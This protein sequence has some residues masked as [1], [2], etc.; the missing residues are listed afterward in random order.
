MVIVTPAKV[1]SGVHEVDFVVLTSINY[2]LAR[3]GGPVKR[4]HSNMTVRGEKK[5]CIC[6]HGGVGTIEGK[7]ARKFA[8][9]LNHSTL[10][11]KATLRELIITCCYAGVRANG[12]QDVG[13]SVIDIFAQTLQIPGLRIQGALGPSIKTTALG[14]AFQVVNPDATKVKKAV[15]TQNQMLQQ[16]GQQLVN[17][18][19]T[20]NQ[21]NPAKQHDDPLFDR[22][23][24]G[25]RK[26]SW[27]KIDSKMDGS[28]TWH[29]AGNHPGMDYIQYKAQKHSDYST[30]FFQNFVN[31]LQHDGLLLDSH[32]NMRTVY[33][34]GNTVVTEKPPK[35][36]NRW[37]YITTATAAALGLPD[38][39]AEL[40]VLRRFRDEVLLRCPSGRRDVQE[41]YATA[42][43]IVAAIDRLPEAGA[44]YRHLYRQSI[45]PAVAAVRAGRHAD[46]YA[47]YRRLVGE[48]HDR[49]R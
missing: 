33:W 25:S 24:G 37:C 6:G 11:C 36:G 46:A 1:S 3:V 45:A 35:S 28:T 17:Q 9:L 20:T 8:D 7:P 43:A 13:T 27:E 15:D 4:F 47:I 23:T 14:T 22:N 42:P 26:L 19:K 31:R 34:D 16:A 2:G 32:H 30:D 5:V 48:A 12:D 29:G 44:I 41:Y 10:G 18:G 38:D 49:Y 39:C 40:T 21:G